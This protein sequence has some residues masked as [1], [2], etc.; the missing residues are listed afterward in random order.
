MGIAPPEFLRRAE[1]LFGEPRLLSEPRD[2]Y[3]SRDR[4]EAVFQLPRIWEQCS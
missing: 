4:E 3:L 1:L 2:S